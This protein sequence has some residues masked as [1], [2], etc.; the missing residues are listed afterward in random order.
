MAAIVFKSTA[1]PFTGKLTYFRV[2]SGTIQS[3]HPVF[4][5]SKGKAEMTSTRRQVEWDRCR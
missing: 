5:G 4:N 2:V 1:D 3:D